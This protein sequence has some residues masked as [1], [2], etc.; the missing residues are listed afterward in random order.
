MKKILFAIALCISAPT[1]AQS[2]ETVLANGNKEIRTEVWEQTCAEDTQTKLINAGIGAAV[3]YAVG[4]YGAKS[5]NS[6]HRQEIS[7]ASAAVG[8][9]AGYNLD[10]TR[11]CRKYKGETVT[12]IDKNGNVI[13]TTFVPA[14]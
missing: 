1:F 2:T 14:E 7:L 9:A 10:K 4:S 6:D 8:A 5:V 11:I 3:A 12:V 13:S